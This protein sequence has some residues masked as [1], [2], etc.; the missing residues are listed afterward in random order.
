MGKIYHGTSGKGV[1]PDN[2]DQWINL[3]ASEYAKKE[4]ND[5]ARDARLKGEI[6]NDVTQL[7][8]HSL[9]LPMFMIIHTRTASVPRGSWNYCKVMLRQRIRLHFFLLSD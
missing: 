2:W 4:N 8:G 1:D 5:I 9:N 6:G 3:E 7:K